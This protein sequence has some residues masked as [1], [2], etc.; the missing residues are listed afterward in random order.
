M[1]REWI[2]QPLDTLFFRGGLPFSAGETGW[3]ESFFPPTPQTIQGLVRYVLLRTTGACDAKD[4]FSCEPC[5]KRDSCRVKQVIGSVGTDVDI[6]DFGTLKITGPC[7]GFKGKRYFPVPLDLMRRNGSLFSLRPSPTITESDVGDLRMPARPEGILQE[8]TDSI[9]GWIEEDVM[10]RYLNDNIPPDDRLILSDDSFFVKEPRVGIKRDVRT[11]SVETGMLYAIVPL[12]FRDDVDIRFRVSNV[13]A[14]CEPSTPVVT[15]FGGEGRT[16]SLNIV[17]YNGPDLPRTSE[18]L[19][20]LV[21]LQPGCFSG[22]CLPDF[23][24]VKNSTGRVT[25]WSGR[26][27]G[28]NLKLVSACTGRAS[29]IGGFDA[30]RKRVKAMRNHVPAGSVYFLEAEAGEDLSKLAPEGT[31]GS[32]NNI[33]FGHY[34]FGR[35]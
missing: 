4:I 7:L 16:V 15:R 12:R 31:I 24:P 28:V 34:R 2:I 26:I 19:I 10:I 20:K 1:E 22:W 6:P 32:N 35:W 23:T 9:H 11:H 3:V 18:R 33:G 25:H 29:K 5:S 30:V 14:E 8:G 27:D 17:D 21:M 13:P